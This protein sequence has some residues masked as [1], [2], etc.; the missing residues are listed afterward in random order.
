MGLDSDSGELAPDGSRPLQLSQGKI[1]VT[2]SP[3][4]F[5]WLAESLRQTVHAL[6]A[7]K[8]DGQGKPLP[9]SPATVENQ[10]I[11]L[12][13]DW[14]QAPARDTNELARLLCVSASDHLL[15][16][17]D[18]VESPTY[19]VFASYTDARGVL[20]QATRAWYLTEPTGEIRERVR[21][22]MNERLWD[23]DESR[24]FLK[25]INEDT[26]RLDD[27]EQSICQTAQVHG[28]VVGKSRSGPQLADPRPSIMK[29]SGLILK[30]DNGTTDF[31]E[32][33][34]RFLSSPTHGAGSG[35]IGRL[36]DVD[37]IKTPG[38]D[39]TT[40]ARYLLWPVN[41]YIAMG[42]RFLDHYGWAKGE[43]ERARQ[44]TLERWVGHA[45]Q[46]L[47]TTKQQ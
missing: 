14:G 11:S 29:L 8:G 39:S 1:S 4:A 44:Q 34:F 30:S 42:D 9:G 47:P 15:A 31:G 5:A 13:G 45:D 6:E 46:G 17:A 37:G 43:W 41:A 28:F 10:D 18:A 7:G 2:E 21:R 12:R 25:G 24:R 36:I 40:M 20:D 23:I 3:D 32:A 27:M 19:G 22:G 38:K 33:A 26:S 16:L 35:L